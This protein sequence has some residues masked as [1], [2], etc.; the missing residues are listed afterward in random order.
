MKNYRQLIKELPSKTVVMSV[1]SFNPPTV[2][3]E[4]AFKLVEK[5]VHSHNADHVIYV[6]EEQNTLPVDRKIH[7][8]E[9]M[10]NQ[11]NFTGINEE[12]LV[13]EVSKLKNRYKNVVIVTSEDKV[14]TFEKALT[15]K[16][17]ESVQVVSTGEQNPDNNKIKSYMT[18]GDYQAFKLQLPSSIRDIDARR[19]MNEMR[20]VAGLEVLKE[21]L[22][23]NIDQLRDKYFKG[24]IY[25]IGDIV[26]SN[27]SQYEI[28]DRGSNYL[29]VVDK[30]GEL[31]RKWIKDVNLVEA[32]WKGY[33]QLGMKKKGG[34]QV[35]NCIPESV[36][37]PKDPHK[38]YA[39]K[40]KTLQD[41]SRN[42]DVDQK[43]VQ[44]RR[45][46]LDKEYSKLKEDA[47]PQVSYKG[48]TTSNFHCCKDTSKAFKLSLAGEINDPVAM[49]N[50]IK[51]TDTYLKINDHSNAKGKEQMVS[52][53]HIKIA[54]IK[55]KEAL[56]KLGIFA[57]HS[58]SWEKHKKQLDELMEESKHDNENIKR[59]AMT[60]QQFMKSGKVQPGF[61]KDTRIDKTPIEPNISQQIDDLEDWPHEV[62]TKVGHTLATRDHLRR[63]KAQY[64]TEES[65]PVLENEEMW[66]QRVIDEDAKSLKAQADKHTEKALAANKAGDDEK[67]K[68]H[69]AQ[70]A[71]IK[72]KMQ[73]EDF[74]AGDLMD[75]DF[76]VTFTEGHGGE[77]GDGIGDDKATKIRTIPPH[78]VPKKD[79]KGVQRTKDL[80]FSAFYEK[81]K[82]ENIDVTAPD[83]VNY[84]LKKE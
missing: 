75:E 51:T 57:N 32:C 17:F 40:S 11:L 3:H 33:K 64:A 6:T 58:E 9:L 20:Q 27:G 78:L 44:Q 7:F 72:A 5:L 16:L 76:A 24:E 55:A 31:H 45:L 73:K 38:D 41:L 42:K 71:K 18:K 30:S 4:M 49:L 12:R 83:L 14:K 15:S 23:F 22:K 63:Q 82:K 61:V 48:Y 68:Y 52:N 37:N 80:S 50:A 70:V 77:I 21:E 43:A 54:H 29:V 84:R 47:D 19:M 74:V 13:E 60:Y 53:K 28:M 62:Q 66:A 34:K 26:E 69:Q 79:P 25:H 59:S 35:P 65:I 1:G 67:V 46:D 39:E 8:L 2:K 36:L 56:S 81:T 10:F